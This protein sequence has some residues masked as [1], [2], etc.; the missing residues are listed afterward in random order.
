M[1]WVSGNDDL[2]QAHAIRREVF[3]I[4]QGVAE[5]IEK[6]AR[7]DEISQHLI[8]FESSKPVATGR[9]VVD[10]GN[11]SLGRIT[12]V[13]EHRGKGYGR[14]VTQEL[15]NKAF[16]IGATEIAIHAQSYLVDFYAGLG[17]KICSDEYEEAGIMHFSMSLRKYAR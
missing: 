11:F 13:K 2:A 9:I 15:I 8:V 4:E 16:A 5:E 17:F 1:K 6:D 12:V 7:Q 14:L 10:N 3:I